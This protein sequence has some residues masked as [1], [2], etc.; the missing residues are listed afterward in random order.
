MKL[1]Y[2]SEQT[3]ERKNTRGSTTA[4]VTFSRSGQISF[5]KPAQEMIGLKNESKIT[6]SQDEDSPEDWYIHIDLSHGFQLRKLSNQQLCFSHTNL[7]KQFKELTELDP[8][9]THTMLIARQP[10]MME[11]DKAKTKYWC[12]LIKR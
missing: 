5:N 2:Y 8:D 12:I 1:K 7:V 11:G 6:L 4:K 3:V 10:T 9:A